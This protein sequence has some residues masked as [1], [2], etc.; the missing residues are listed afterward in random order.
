LGAG[1]P[2]NPTNSIS[3]GR[4]ITTRN[5]VQILA[6]YDLHLKMHNFHVL[7]GYQYDGFRSDFTNANARN[8][9]S[10]DVAS[11]NYP[12]NVAVNTPVVGD[13]IQTRVLISYFG[14][15]N[16]NF[17]NKY[18]IEATLRHDASSQLS[19][20]Y[21][22][23]LFPAV[24]A[25]WNIH[26]ETWFENTLPFFNEFKLRASWG[27]LG[28][29]SVLGNY[30]YIAL[31][32][33][34]PVYPFNNVI[35]NSIYQGSYASL[36]KQ[37]EVIETYNYGIDLQLLNR[38]LSA[39]FDYFIR[40]NNNMLITPTVPAVF[41]VSPAQRNDANLETKGWEALLNW[42]DKVGAV[43]YF[44]SFNIADAKNK[45]VKYNGQ[46]VYSSGVRSIIEGL[47]LNTIW[48]YQSSGY[49]QNA[50]DVTAGPFQ[51][52]RTGPGDLRYI[53]LD[54]NNK[55][56]GGSNTKDDHG[57]LV[58]LGETTPHYTYGA[59]LGL[60]WKG[61][62]FSVI[63]QGVGQ[64]KMLIYSYAAL[65]YMESWRQSWKINNDYWTPDNPNALF[66]RPFL[67]GTHNA[68]VSDKW[69]QDASYIRLKNLQVG[70]TLPASL[71]NKI[72]IS[73]LRVYFSG[74]DLWESTGMWYKYYDPEQPNNT[75]F[76][77][78]L[79]RSYAF[80]INVTF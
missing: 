59:N 68:V 57:D 7:G 27:Q 70:Y 18:L 12:S 44:V 6:D 5:N 64:R 20:G 26:R 35:N 48:G 65:P 24:S 8:L 30:D 47:P 74:Q 41:G 80:G 28:N 75:S 2:I 1:N 17:D 52:N 60:E 9:I 11:L 46:N 69:V 25:G 31:L 36:E 73:K 72:K 49:Y 58:N 15:L 77:Y 51:D 62:D 79:F 45:V 40:K 55:I 13:N 10:N 22:D 66:P 76:D 19:P 71:T 56:N 23:K 43:N 33:R 78:P 37:W 34:G 4:T 32:S 39:S 50:A 53:D 63:T 38:R 54:K 3:K 16:Y 14:R 67:G 61:I 29:S 42:K 21:R